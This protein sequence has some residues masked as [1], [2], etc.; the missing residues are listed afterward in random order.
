MPRVKQTVRLAL[1]PTHA[2]VQQALQVAA[3]DFQHAFAPA[4]PALTKERCQFLCAW[5]R[6]AYQ[7]QDVFGAP[8]PYDELGLTDY[9]KLVPHPMDIS[10]VERILADNPFD[11]PRFLDC[12]RL[13]FA[14][15]VRFNPPEDPY[16][17]LARRLAAAFDERVIR[18]QTAE[19]PDENDDKVEICTILHPLLNHL[20][21][22]T[23]AVAFVDP[24]DIGAYP[25]YPTVVVRPMCLRD[26]MSGLE[27]CSYVHRADVSLDGTPY[28]PRRAH[29]PLIFFSY[30]FGLPRLRS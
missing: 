8:V 23:D 6:G 21:Q 15:A 30:P 17:H 10:L 22:R 12:M 25:N 20:V 19:R 27:K 5:M 28:N 24:V 13:V 26:I 2:E 7:C 29:L 18:M 14:N 11:F 9:R 4:S 1:P 16:H 3:A